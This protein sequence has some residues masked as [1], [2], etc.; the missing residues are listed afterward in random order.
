MAERTSGSPRGPLDGIRVLDFTEN[1]AGP[2]GTMM[3]GDQGAD[4]IKIESPSGD[5]IRHQ[6]TG[7]RAMSACFAN[8][9]RSK[10]S[11]VMDLL[12]E[13]SRPV[14]SSLIDSADVV[15]QSFRPAASKRLGLD[16]ASV[17]I[18]R[19][20]IIHASIV[21]FGS[22]GPMA[23]LP[24]Y[25]HVVQALSGMTDLQRESATDAP[26]LIRHGLV[27]KS[28]G[29][30]LAESIC[31]A[32]IERF[33]T[34][35]G[36]S[37]EISMLD[38]AVSFLWPDGMMNHSVLHPELLRPAV[39]LTFR[40]TPT[41]DGHVS[42]VIMKQAHWDGL[43]KALN[44]DA[45]VAGFQAERAG[46]SLPGE[47]LRAARAIVATLP[48]Q[49][50]VERLARFDVPC[51]PVRKLEEIADDP[52]IQANGTLVSYDHPLAGS[53]RQARATPQIPSMVGADIMPAPDLGEHSRDVL[54][55]IGL[56]NSDVDDLVKLGVVI[57]S[58]TS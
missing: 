25:D 54:R 49:E 6:G 11:L 5:I 39:A 33:R 16:Y 23:G 12:A 27:D 43:I 4:V 55:E 48:T 38:V 37:F 18:G 57:E 28:T 45:D 7:S 52:Q 21:G 3:L 10:R 58:S 20:N 41:L 17:S 29:Y 31:A 44:L 26:H 35:A 50:V 47:V 9:N 15:V 32:L 19:P 2:F 14:L 13:S 34:G 30:V 22:T 51:A 24:V 56:N 42:M 1:M 8:L 40:L 36:T 46:T 53:I